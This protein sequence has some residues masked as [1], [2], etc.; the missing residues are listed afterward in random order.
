MILQ[1]QMPIAVL[2]L[3]ITG[4]QIQYNDNHLWS[5]IMDL[6]EMYGAINLE[7]K[8]DFLCIPPYRCVTGKFVGNL[9]KALQTNNPDS[10]HRQIYAS[11]NLPAQRAYQMEYRY[12]Y[13]DIFEPFL[14]VIEYATYDSLKGNWIC[15]YL[16]FL[17]IVE[18]VIRQWY[19]KIPG[20]SFSGMK[21]T[22]ELYK[23]QPLYTDE[24]KAITD[25]YVDYLKYILEDVLYIRFEDYAKK[26]YADTFNRNLSL[27]KLSGVTN[28][29][30]GMRNLTRLLLVL[31]ILAELYLMQTPQK[32]WKLTFYATPENIDYQVRFELYKKL[33]SVSIGPDDLFVVDNCFISKRLDNPEKQKLIETNKLQEQ[34]GNI[35]R[36]INQDINKLGS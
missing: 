9:Y 18:A 2:L 3:A 34:I 25:G 16:A 24:R 21:K 5:D 26:G 31:D 19:E 14:P 7:L 4:Q 11:V 32:Y 8:K 30:E 10:L 1:I 27:H 17:P 12:K 29:K 15:A 33:R 23:D 20:L 13:C 35:I 6:W 28:S 36:R 22:S